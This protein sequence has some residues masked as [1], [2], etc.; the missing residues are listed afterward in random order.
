LRP[1]W[2]NRISGGLRLAGVSTNHLWALRQL[3]SRSPLAW[4]DCRIIRSLQRA[5]TNS[6]RRHFPMAASFSRSFSLPADLLSRLDESRTEPN[7]KFCQRLHL[8]EQQVIP[9]HLMPAESV[10]NA[11]LCPPASVSQEVERSE[12]IN[13]IRKDRQAPSHQTLVEQHRV[14]EA[15]EVMRGN[16]N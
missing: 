7:C 8:R 12:Y 9:S 4:V 3:P 15:N 2:S 16:S 1:E 6:I 5:S 14:R 10:L 13:F 11:S